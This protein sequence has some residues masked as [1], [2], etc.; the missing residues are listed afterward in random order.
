MESPLKRR[1]RYLREKAQK[2]Q[3]QEQ[4]AKDELAAKM[5]ATFGPPASGGMV[6]GAPRYVTTTSP[7]TTKWAFA[8]SSASWTITFDAPLAKEP[9]VFGPQPAKITGHNDVQVNCT[10]KDRELIAGSLVAYRRFHS[11]VAGVLHGSS[12]MKWT[13][14]ENEAECLYSTT[15]SR[16]AERKTLVQHD[17][18]VPFE[19]CTCGFYAYHTVNPNATGITCTPVMGVY[20]YDGV[21]E[22]Y[23]R[24]LIGETGLRAQKA[25]IIALAP[26]ADQSNLYMSYNWSGLTDDTRR[27]LE[28]PLMWEQRT[29]ALAMLYPM[30]RNIE[31]LVSTYKL[32]SGQ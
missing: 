12:G 20:A 31:E 3:E 23:G 6:L 11:P 9:P 17:D 25:R 21:V 1:E 19:D 28:S 14:G 24:V 13:P 4:K 18:A 29:K 16:M 8:T 30:A 22:F 10:G 2:Q 7:S 27:M 5:R 32:T 15:W 26:A